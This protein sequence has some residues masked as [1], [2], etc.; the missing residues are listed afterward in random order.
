MSFTVVLVGVT[1]DQA[2]NAERDLGH[3][4]SYSDTYA[5]L[6]LLAKT[7]LSINAVFEEFTCSSAACSA[8]LDMLSGLKVIV[9]LKMIRGPVFELLQLD[10]RQTVRQIGFERGWQALR[11]KWR[12][13]S[14]PSGSQEKNKRVLH[15]W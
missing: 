5:L 8:D 7:T 13:Q 2:R 3:D 6:S 11:S 14:K 10:L 15:R 9:V 1:F 12:G 4:S